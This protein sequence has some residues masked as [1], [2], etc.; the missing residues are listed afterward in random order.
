MLLHHW[1]DV[2]LKFKFKIYHYGSK[3]FSTNYLKIFEMQ[4]SQTIQQNINYIKWECKNIKQPHQRSHFSLKCGRLFLYFFWV[5]IYSNYPKVLC[6]CELFYFIILFIVSHFMC[7][8][9][10][11]TLCIFKKF[12]MLN[13]FYPI[14]ILSSV[15]SLIF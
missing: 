2:L 1:A 14:R 7:I 15:Y 3:I 12:Y 13:F 9:L 6:F 4:A 11:C 10:I 5:S 8:F